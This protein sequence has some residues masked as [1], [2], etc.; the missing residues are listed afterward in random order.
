MGAAPLATNPVDVIRDANFV[1]F[2]NKFLFK[3]VRQYDRIRES[4]DALPSVQVGVICLYCFKIFICDCF[5]F[6]SFDVYL[7]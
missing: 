3:K 1:P 5:D 4:L 2:P 6:V 7:V